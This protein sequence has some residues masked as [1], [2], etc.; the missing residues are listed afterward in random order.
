MIKNILNN[1]KK[2]TSNLQ[3]N[4]VNFLNEIFIENEIKEFHEKSFIF[5][6]LRGKFQD[7]NNYSLNFEY[8]YF[9]YFFEFYLSYDQLEYFI[10]KQN[11][12]SM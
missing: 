6:G 10:V 7:L 11:N 5:K 3:I 8:N 12:K 1:N 4:C 9:Q 2:I